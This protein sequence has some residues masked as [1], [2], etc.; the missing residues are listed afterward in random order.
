[1]WPVLGEQAEQAQDVR[2]LQEAPRR[3]LARVRPGQVGNTLLDKYDN[4]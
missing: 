1:M 2:A 4:L 3:P